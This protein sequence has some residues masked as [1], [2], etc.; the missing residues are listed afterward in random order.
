MLKQLMLSKKIEGLRSTLNEFLE[1]EAK[2]TTRSEDLEASIEEAET[3]EEIEVVEEE[4]EKLEEEKSKLEEKKSK[5]EGEIAELEGELE[6]LNSNK[7]SNTQRNKEGDDKMELR[8]AIGTYVRNKKIGEER[9]VEGFK[10]VDGG[11][12]VPEELLKPEKEKEATIDLTKYVREIKVNR[13]SGS[14]P[15][16]KKSD[17]RM[18]SVAELEKNPE[19]AKPKIED[20]DYKVET[21]RGYI[22]VSQEVI[23]DADYDIVGLIS[24][25]IKDQDLNTKNYKI[26]EIL[27]GA[28]STTAS[29]FDGLKDVVNTKIKKVYNIKAFLSSSMFNSLDKI[30]DKNG[31][32]ILQDSIT[33][34][35]GKELFGLIDIDEVLDDDMIGEEAGDMVAFIGDP[36]EF[37]TLFD[38]KR[39]SVKWVDNN[40][41]GE[42]L[43]GFVR[44]D[45]KEVDTEAGYY[46]TYTPETPEA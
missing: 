38:R 7:P 12:L 31:R 40:I 44:F 18:V 23:D 41:Y 20:I 25:D 37:A 24:E 6:K 43:A 26:L 11:A 4:V 16:I 27:K 2:L 15:V 21:Y 8:E 10:V 5:L 30:K 34:K 17:G 45:V 36:Y 22:P 28:P 29:G 32:Y 13:G 9:A 42:L 19:L 35:T 3:D 46:V 39:A 33:A 1:E 14:F